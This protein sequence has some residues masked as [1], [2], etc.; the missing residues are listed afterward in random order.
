VSQSVKKRQGHTSDQGEVWN[1]VSALHTMHG[2]E[3]TTHAMS[4]AFD[5]HQDTIAA[6]R[7]KLQ[8]IPGATGVAVAIGERVIS[9]DLFDKPS[10]CENVWNRLLTG[11][12]FDALESGKSDQ[13]VSVSD[14]EHLLRAASDL[15]WEQAQA[16]GEGEE[17]RAESPKGDHA[18]A[19]A[20]ED[21]VV[22]G[23]VLTAA[24]P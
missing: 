18:S 13:S 14:V 9:V 20:F 5:K 16:V 15:P 2:V 7:E 3:S 4:D 21:T 8:Y 22:H 12:V 11:V 6:F 23:S 10:T 1:Q 24:T 19:L 17:Y